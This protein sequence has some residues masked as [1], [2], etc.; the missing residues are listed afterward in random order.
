VDD[1]VDGWVYSDLVVVGG[2]G[3]GGGGGCDEEWV[4][5]DDGVSDE[6]VSYP[7]PLPP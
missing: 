3:G 6:V 4:Y 2:G 7:P 5:S 1:E